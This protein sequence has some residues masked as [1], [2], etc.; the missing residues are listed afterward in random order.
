MSFYDYTF[1]LCIPPQTSAVHKQ[2]TISKKSVRNI[3]LKKKNSKKLHVTK[4]LEF[5]P[6]CLLTLDK[7]KLL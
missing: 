6:S 7:R 5:D 3:L 4:S 2:S 1:G